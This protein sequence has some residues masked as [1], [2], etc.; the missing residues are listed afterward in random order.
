VIPQE[1]RGSQA[2]QEC[3]NLFYVIIEMAM[4][5]QGKK[6]DWFDLGAYA[7]A[8]ACPGTYAVPTYVCP[9]CPPAVAE[10]NDARGAVMLRSSSGGERMVHRTVTSRRGL[11]TYTSPV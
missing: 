9:I 1:S 4:P 6:R 3:A 10:Q 11:Q 2:Q 7:F 5:Q 8:K